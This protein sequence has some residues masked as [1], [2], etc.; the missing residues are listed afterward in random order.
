MLLQQIVVACHSLTVQI[1]FKN[2]KIPQYPQPGRL[3]GQS[4]GMQKEARHGGSGFHVSEVTSITYSGQAELCERPCVCCKSFNDV[5][6]P[7]KKKLVQQNVKGKMADTCCYISGDLLC[8]FFPLFV[9]GILRNTNQKKFS[10]WRHQTIYANFFVL[11]R[12]K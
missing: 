7:S 8:A 12:P 2:R 9:D 4:D 10:K 11:T 1:S 3:L 6:K 5:Q